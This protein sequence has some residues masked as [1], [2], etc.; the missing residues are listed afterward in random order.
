MSESRLP[1]GVLSV[2]VQLAASLILVSP[3]VP[4]CHAHLAQLV[5]GVANSNGGRSHREEDV[6]TVLNFFQE[7]ADKYSGFEYVRIIKVWTFSGT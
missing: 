6:G 2:A 4:E 5:K 7:L 1:G 3:N